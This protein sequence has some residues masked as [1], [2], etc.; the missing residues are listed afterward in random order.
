MVAAHLKIVPMLS[1]GNSHIAMKDAIGARAKKMAM[2]K[3]TNVVE[4][5]P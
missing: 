2:D 3:F 4:L 5:I 1:F